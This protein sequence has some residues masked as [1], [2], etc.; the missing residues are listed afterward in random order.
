MSLTW[1]PNL[2]SAVRLVLG[3]AFPW[4]PPEWRLPVIMVAALT[5]GI[6]GQLS[7]WL[8]A[9]SRLGRILDP[10]ADKF[11]F[12]M[13]AVTLLLGGTLRL[14]ELLV[15]GLRDWTV[16]AGALAALVRDGPG[17]WRRMPPRI[18]GKLATV[19]QFLFLAVVLLEWDAARPWLFVIA[20][21]VSGLAGIDYVLAYLRFREPADPENQTAS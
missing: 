14:V 19:G 9:E 3:I 10:V 6:D 21:L 2:I 4:C 16:G 12:A 18:L 1:L 7:R 15:I 8:G 17:A 20:G 11:F 13:V 5:D